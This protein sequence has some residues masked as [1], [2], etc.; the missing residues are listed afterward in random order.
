MYFLLTLDLRGRSPDNLEFGYEVNK[1]W[2]II[3]PTKNQIF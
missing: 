3:I 2:P 1:V